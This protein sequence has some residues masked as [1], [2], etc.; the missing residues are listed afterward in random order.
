MKA[1][2]SK[3]RAARQRWRQ[4]VTSARRKSLD[5]TRKR[6]ALWWVTVSWAVLSAACCAYRFLWSTFPFTGVDEPPGSWS[7]VFVGEIAVA[8][9]VMLTLGSI[10]LLI[11]GLVGFRR[12]WRSAVVWAAAGAAGVVLEISY[13]FAFGAH[14]VSPIYSGPAVVDWLYLPEA[15]GLLLTGSVMAW[16][17]SRFPAVI[18]RASD[19]GA[20]SA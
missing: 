3:R 19:P 7:V 2:L 5:M 18:P 16:L 17:V 15:A 10:P 12:A 20:V 11:A 9:G 4:F 14:W 13:L 1:G 6:G 8:I